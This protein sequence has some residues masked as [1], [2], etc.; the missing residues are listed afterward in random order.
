[1]LRYVV[2][3]FVVLQPVH[4]F[5]QGYVIQIKQVEPDGEMRSAECIRKMTVCKVAVP[6][7][8]DDKKEEIGVDVT[9]DTDSLY[10]Q[11]LWKDIYLFQSKQSRGLYSL[12]ADI[13]Q[14]EIKRISVYM[15]SKLEQ[16][17]TSE[18][19][20]HRTGSKVI[21]NLEVTITPVQ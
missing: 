2:L 18:L 12:D 10:F 15:P 1:M 13:T 17:D 3:G 7:I 6:I 8:R 11:F 20:V 16:D 5:A 9:F 14:K 4:A 19:A 21:A